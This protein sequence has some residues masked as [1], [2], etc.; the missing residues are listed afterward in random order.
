MIGSNYLQ[1]VV[2]RLAGKEKVFLRNLLNQHWDGVDDY[3]KVTK[4]LRCSVW[5]NSTGLVSGSGPLRAFLIDS[6]SS[7]EV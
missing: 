3:I 6:E 5:T 2:G 7:G 4:W 1:S